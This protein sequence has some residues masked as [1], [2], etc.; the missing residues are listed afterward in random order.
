MLPTN[1]SKG[2]TKFTKKHDLTYGF[3][4]SRRADAFSPLWDLDVKTP[5]DTEWFKLV[6]A[7]NLATCVGK[8]GYCLERDGL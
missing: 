4:I 3:R 7:D 5:T 1:E 6:D 8:V 2:S